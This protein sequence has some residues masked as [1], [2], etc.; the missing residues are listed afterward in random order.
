MSEIG[1]RFLNNV[2]SDNIVFIYFFGILLIFL[3]GRGLRKSLFTGAKYSSV[4]LF[5]S[6]L[7][8]IISGWIPGQE[9][10]LLWVFLLSS[11]IGV[12]ILRKWGELKGEWLGMPEMIIVMAPFVGLQWFVLEQGIE[13]F[14]RIFALT[15]SVF[16]FYLAFILVASIREQI[17]ISEMSD[18]F[19]K[20][21]SLL[22]IIAFIVLA[23]VG[24]TFV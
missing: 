13:Y 23:L 21:A 22:M 5:I 18:I 3:K 15:A 20:E 6:I 17:Q 4:L 16:G 11:L 12:F 9:F 10:L 24:F 7:S 8:W 19:K 14:A 2:L 1:T